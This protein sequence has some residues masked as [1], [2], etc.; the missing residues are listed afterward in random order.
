MKIIKD[1]KIDLSDMSAVSQARNFT[2][3]G[4]PN[5]IFSLEI[6]NEDATPTYY[7]FD[8]KTFST[9]KA[10]LERKRLIDGSYSNSITFPA[11]TDDD[12]YDI[13]L[14]AENGYDTFHSEYKEVRFAD[15]TLDINSSKGSNSSLLKKII[16]QYTDT[17]ITLSA[18]SPN[19]VTVFDSVSITNATITAARNQRINSVPFSVVVTA[20]TTKAFFIK[21]QPVASDITYSEARTL[22]ADP[23][24]IVGE[25][26]YPAVSNTDTVNNDVTSGI[27][28]TMDTAVA[29]KVTVG[30]RITGNA[31]L[32]AKVVTVVALTGTYT[33]TMSEAIA[34]ADGITLSFSNRVNYRWSVAGTGVL[35]LTSGIKPIGTNITSGSILSSLEDT[36][37]YTTIIEDEYGGLTNGT[38]TVVNFSSPVTD[39]LSQKPTITNGVISAQ[40]GD[41]TFNNQQ[42]LALGGDSVTFY[43]YGP[44]QIKSILGPEIELTN[45]SIALTKPTTTTTEATSA[46]ATIAVADREGVINNISQVSGIGINPAVA[47]PFLTTGGGLDG[48]GDWIMDATQ[49]LENGITLTVENTSRVATIT[50]NISITKV[51][52]GNFTLKF[53]LEQLLSA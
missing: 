25:D 21:K 28:V 45:L 18:V 26:I 4:D 17:T 19:A 34:I 33:F 40:L 39:T 27:T 23:V 16:Y 9:T 48:A 43:A 11:I 15:G 2:V 38:N 29:S 51:N 31:A 7:N 13:Y 8:T 44:D 32:D 30:D 24:A 37:T 3:S 5:A 47:D 1:F 49:T 46:H 6:R 35:G 14:F 50:G 22:G 41:V 20:A 10:R 53:D 12:H 42:K 52:K 36:T